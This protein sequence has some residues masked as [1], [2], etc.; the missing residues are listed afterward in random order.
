MSPRVGTRPIELR[1]SAPSLDNTRSTNRFAALGFDGRAARAMEIGA[2][3]M[4]LTGTQSTGAPRAQHAEVPIIGTR[5]ERDLAVTPPGIEQI[6]PPARNF[7]R[8]NPLAV[9]SDRV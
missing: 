5:I 6:V 1:I 8:P 2:A 9:V 7:R 4:G 3:T